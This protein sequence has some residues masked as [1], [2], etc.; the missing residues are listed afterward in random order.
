MCLNDKIKFLI[1]NNILHI[2]IEYYEVLLRIYKIRIA[3]KMFTRILSSKYS[4][5][6]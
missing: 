2:F 1:Y 3:D 6:Y 5:K 4:V